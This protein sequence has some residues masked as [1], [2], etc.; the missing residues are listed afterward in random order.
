[1]TVLFDGEIH[2]HYRF[3]NLTIAGEMP[4]VSRAS[5]GQR[6]GLC[7]AGVPDALAM[8]T[9]LHTGSVPFTMTWH[10]TEPPVSDEWEEVVEVPFA[11]SSTDLTLSAFDHFYGVRLPATG[12]LRARYCA[13]GLDEA[14]DAD[15]RMDEPPIDHYLLEL[16]PAPPAPDAVLRQTSR[17]AAYW[18]DHARK[19]P[20]PP[21]AEER[22]AAR[23]AEEQRLA[24][25][26][27]EQKAAAERREWGGRAPTPRLRE[28]TGNARNMARSHRDLLDE[29]AAQPPS[30]QREIATWLARQAFEI[31]DLT[32]DPAA[33]A[34]LTA[35]ESGDPLPPPFDTPEAAYDHIHPR[36]TRNFVGYVSFGKPTGP[37]PPIHRPSFAV[38]ALFGAAESDPLQAIVEAFHHTEATFD[39]RKAELVPALRSR[40]LT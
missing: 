16:W 2:V 5:G 28:L 33:A 29:L 4:D 7:G 37:R 27:A 30:A 14:A 26:R 6:N 40:W 24:A 36:A 1:M 32:G 13:R 25:V 39:D 38:P 22:A 21:T 23:A 35:L 34:A 15:T 31:A 8:I 18:H 11:P 10:E 9:G 3:I 17:Y 20:P 19:T 12:S